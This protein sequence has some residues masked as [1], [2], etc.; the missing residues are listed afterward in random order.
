MALPS[1][2]PLSIAQIRLMFGGSAPHSL[3]EYYKGGFRVLATDIAPNVPTSGAISIGNFYGSEIV[4]NYV[5]TMAQGTA[6]N[7]EYN[8]FPSTASLYVNDAGKADASNNN[9]SQFTRDWLTGTPRSVYEVR[10]T[11][12]GDTTSGTGSTDIIG[13]FDVWREV[14]AGIE[15]TVTADDG[16]NFTRT[17]QMKVDIRRMADLVVVSTTGTNLFTITAHSNVG[18]PP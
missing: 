1:S 9:F 10:F 17:I 5:A 12:T 18:L 11:K 4:E 15:L 14:G 8:A 13:A 16:V 3:S 7:N 6:R 2:G